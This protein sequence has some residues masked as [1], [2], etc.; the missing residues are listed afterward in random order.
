MAVRKPDDHYAGILSSHQRLREIL[1]SFDLTL[2]GKPC[3][4]VRFD[5]LPQ[6]FPDVHLAYP[7]QLIARL[8]REVLLDQVPEPEVAL[9]E[10]GPLRNLQHH[11]PSSVHVDL[12][13]TLFVDRR[14]G[15]AEQSH[16]DDVGPPPLVVFFQPDHRRVMKAPVQEYLR[17]VP[18]PPFRIVDD[19]R[20]ASDLLGDQFE[21]RFSDYEVELHVRQSPTD[22]LLVCTARIW[23]ET[24]EEA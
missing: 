1:E 10:P 23:R 8:F 20:E 7:D 17:G 21:R 18:F 15:D 12:D 9:R 5:Y 6:E 14:P 11:I 24:E 16:E 2:G 13:G 4:E 22:G 19:S 3:H